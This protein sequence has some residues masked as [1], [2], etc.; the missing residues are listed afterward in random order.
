MKSGMPVYSI[1]DVFSEVQTGPLGNHFLIS[2]SVFPAT[3]Q[4]PMR[5]DFYAI[6]YC[7]KGRYK[8]KTDTREC[9]LEPGSL[10]F[11]RPGELHRLINS[12]NYEGILIAF[13]SN[14]FI[15][16]EKSDKHVLEQPFLKNGTDQVILLREEDR[17]HL[18]N[19]I[20]GIFA[21]KSKTENP[22][23]YKIIRNLLASIIYEL[24]A[25]Y[26]FGNNVVDVPISH[27]GNILKRFEQLLNVHFKKQHNVRFYADSLYITPGYL[28]ELLKERRGKNASELI[29]EKLLL[30]AQILLKTTSE[31][32]YKISELLNFSNAGSFIRFFKH[33]TDLPPAK[34][35]K[36]A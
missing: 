19:Y 1:R 16:E 21:V 36:T 15:S 28:S 35:R 30:E 14:F 8:V 20:K 2:D 34:Y 13:T 4:A 24:S 27:T 12:H 23:R 3:T 29:Q 7:C 11:F 26:P 6:A 5:H 32:I 33:H 25:L 9:S 31:N 18:S 10:M 17:L 22:H